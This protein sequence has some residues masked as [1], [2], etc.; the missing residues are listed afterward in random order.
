MMQAGGSPRQPDILDFHKNLNR[1][2]LAAAA[3]TI[4]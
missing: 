4:L 3:W 2:G 1:A